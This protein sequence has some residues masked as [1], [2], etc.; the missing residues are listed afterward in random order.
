M[1]KNVPFRLVILI[2]EEVTH[3]WGQGVYEKSLYLPLN[4]V[5]NEKLL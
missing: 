3:V 1:V 2:M 5:V 4:F